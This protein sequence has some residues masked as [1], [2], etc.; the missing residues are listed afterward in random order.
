MKCSKCGMEYDDTFKFCPDCGEPNP[1][2]ASP[3]G[4]IA[5]FK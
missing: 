2:A 3:A 1:I 5:T 4:G